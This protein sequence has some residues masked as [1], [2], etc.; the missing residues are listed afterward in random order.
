MQ[1][2]RFHVVTYMDWNIFTNFGKWHA[3]QFIKK[4][5][6]VP[7]LHRKSPWY[8]S[9]IWSAI[10]LTII[11]YLENLKKSR[12]MFPQ[13]SYNR[14]GTDPV[15]TLS[16]TNNKFRLPVLTDTKRGRPLS[17]L[18]TIQMEQNGYLEL[19]KYINEKRNHS[20]FKVWYTVK[21]FLS[22]HSK[23][24]QNLVFKTDHCVTG[25]K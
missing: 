5:K 9:I 20:L 14:L 11:E 8:Y 23:I 19:H 2:I 1:I 15:Q 24:R 21:P 7:I 22:G 18:Y 4:P 12:T 17:G 6:L 16:Y 3:F 10:N 25:E 13:L